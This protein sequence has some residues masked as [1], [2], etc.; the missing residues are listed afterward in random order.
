MLV[1]LYLCSKLLHMTKTLLAVSLSILIFTTGCKTAQRQNN[2]SATIENAYLRINPDSIRASLKVLTSEEL[3]GRRTG[4]EG[5][6][7]AT[8]YLTEYYKRLGIATPPNTVEYTQKIP[9]SFM[10]GATLKLKDS[11]N[12][13]AFIEGSEKPEEVVII[14]AHYD[15][16]GILLGQTYYGADDNGSG[17]SAVMEMARVFQELVNQGIKPKRSILFLH[18]TGEEFGLFGSKYYVSNPIIPLVNTVANINIDMIGRKS[19]EFKGTEDFI[20]VVGSNKISQDLQDACE[21]TNKATVNLVL[22]YKFDNDNDPQQIYYRSDHYS[23]AEKGI[24]AVFF[25]N[26]THDDYHLPTDTFDKI[27]FSLLTKRTQLIFQTAFNISNAN[28]KPRITTIN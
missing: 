20:F 11:E 12:V 14:S 25:Y 8:A 13:W 1:L 2:T 17:T 28:E 21:A 5:Q 26:G 3:G 4:E 18:L 6:K 23:F 22:D 15:H 7:K 24:P 10:K 27:D 19:R 16:L 9:A